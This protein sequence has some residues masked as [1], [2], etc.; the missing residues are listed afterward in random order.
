CRKAV[1]AGCATPQHRAALSCLE[2]TV[3]SCLP[4]RWPLSLRPRGTCADLLSGDH[5]SNAA[6][7]KQADSV[8]SAKTNREEPST[9]RQLRSRRSR[10]SGSA[11]SARAS[12]AACCAAAGGY[13]CS[14]GQPRRLHL[15][16]R[17]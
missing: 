9:C 11:A 16:S 17:P 6:R 2:H 8:G 7:I 13:V 3:G 4:V 14:T 10:L 5:V 12:S 15:S 1:L